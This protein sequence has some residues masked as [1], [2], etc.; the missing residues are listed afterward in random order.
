MLNDGLAVGGEEF[1]EGDV[2]G[3]LKVHIRLDA[4]GWYWFNQPRS[5]P[6]H[7]DVPVN[8]CR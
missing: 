8:G 6:M 1:G 4:G 2:G 7:S 5:L 3:D